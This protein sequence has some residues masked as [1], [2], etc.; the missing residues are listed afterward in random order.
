MPDRSEI[1]SSTHKVIAQCGHN[2]LMERPDVAVPLVLDFLNEKPVPARN[3][4]PLSYQ[5]P[6]EELV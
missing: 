5:L 6:L 2:P 3:F 4:Y 1:P